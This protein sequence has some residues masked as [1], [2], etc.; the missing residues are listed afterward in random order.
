MNVNELKPT[1]LYGDLKLTTKQAISQTKNDF[2][3]P[4]P[5]YGKEKTVKGPKIL[6]VI[7]NLCPPIAIALF[8]LREILELTVLVSIV[9]WL[10]LA[11]T[12]IIILLQKFLWK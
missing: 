10:L 9:G 4:M 3:E 2:E 6:T 12:V 1:E 11:G 8:W 5:F 7:R